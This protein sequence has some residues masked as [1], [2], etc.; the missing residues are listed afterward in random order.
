MPSTPCQ[1][2]YQDNTNCREPAVEG[3]VFCIWHHCD[4]K[5]GGLDIKKE[6]EERH[7][8]GDRLEGFNLEGADLDGITL[9]GANLSRAN[10]KRARFHNAHLYGANLQGAN[11]FKADLTRAN[12]KNSNLDGAELLGAHFQGT[13]MEHAQF[14][15]R[16]RLKNER[17]GDAYR[18]QG[19]IAKANEK[20]IEAEEIYRKIRTNFKNKGLSLSGGQFFYRE[21][22]MKRRQ[23]NP[24]S[25]DRFFSWL[26]EIATGYGEKPYRII[27]FSCG[28]ILAYSIIFG[29]LGIRHSS[30]LFL[31]FSPGLSL[32]GNCEVFFNAMYYSVV[33]FTTLGYGDFTPLGIGKVAA[34]T[35]AFSGAFLI[36]LFV[37]TVYK[38]YMER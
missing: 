16:E 8:R 7:R 31:R 13:K 24:W 34:M 37:I 14:G 6:L 35:E 23:M 17:D 26:M 30:G 5:K 3:A 32:W 36:S 1:Y 33:T 27:G 15:A 11:L 10:L 28:I 38:H 12:L 19:E 22:V 25:V 21:M 18:R 4:K 9:T 2:R 29:L 20:Y